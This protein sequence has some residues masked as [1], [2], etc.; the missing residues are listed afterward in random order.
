[1]TFFSGRASAFSLALALCGALAACGGEASEQPAADDSTAVEAAET[2][3]VV[4]AESASEP[5]PVTL[6]AVNESGVEGRA[7]KIN[8]DDSVQL[9]LMVQGLPRDG[10][11]AAHIH[12]GTCVSGGEV[13]VQLNPVKAES[14]GMGRSMTMIPADRLPEDQPHFVQ[15]RGASGVL[16]CGDVHG[17]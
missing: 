5:L 11:Y 9:S 17:S 10:E 14:D 13:V 4:A 7:T 15:V 3:P 12:R 8:V 2:A 1:M 6:E 16:A